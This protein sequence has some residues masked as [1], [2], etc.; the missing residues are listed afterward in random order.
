M[1]Y[2]IKLTD[3]KIATLKDQIILVLM[4]YSKFS[5]HLG[6]GVA[7]EI[8]QRVLDNAQVISDKP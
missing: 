7:L 6:H 2:K 4:D 5:K 8:A 3:P 1:R